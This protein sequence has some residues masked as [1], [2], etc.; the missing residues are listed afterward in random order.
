MK[1]E[2]K[3]LAYPLIIALLFI[4]YSPQVF[5]EQGKLGLVIIAH[6]SPMPSWNAP[7]IELEEDV[8]VMLNEKGDNPFTS[9]RVALM[10]FSE[11]SINTVIKGMETSGIDRV[12]AI[13]VLIAPSGHSL[14]DI[15]TILGLY[16]EKEMVQGIKEEGTT[17]VDTKIK[18]TLGPTLDSGDVLKQI[19]LDRLK[20]M[21]T[22]PESEGV[23]LI[24]HGDPGYQPRWDSICRD[25]GYHICAKTGIACFDY[26]YAEVGQTFIA[27][28]VPVI[29]RMAEKCDR[30]I[31]IGLYLS[32]G[33]ERMANNSSLSIGRMKMES[34]EILK[35]YNIKFAK[36]GILP[37]RRISEW[38]V[39]KAL[40]WAGSLKENIN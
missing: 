19:M 33:V 20:E 25:I 17:I 13:P 39:E 1:L 14:F 21:S 8:T 22:S 23:V 36:Q 29:L 38:I 3:K 27:E 6:G 16:F 37:D 31:V 4:A 34:K 15:P 30:T 18:I 35:D 10:E 24:A 40:E 2:L 7:V 28:G 11:P 26:A 5:C 12:Y 32:M 9:V